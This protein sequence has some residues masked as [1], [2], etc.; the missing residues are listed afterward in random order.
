MRD[1]VEYGIPYGPLGRIAHA[2]CVERWLKKIFDYRAAM[3]ARLMEAEDKG[4][5]R[6]ERNRAI[7]GQS[8]RHCAP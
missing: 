6:I 4:E 7:A 3:M 1:L 8:S 5:E 2:L